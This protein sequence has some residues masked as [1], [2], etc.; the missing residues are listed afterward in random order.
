MIHLPAMWMF[1]YKNERCTRRTWMRYVAFFGLTVVSTF[2][3]YGYASWLSKTSQSEVFLLQMRPP[4][5]WQEMKDVWEIVR[6]DWIE[7]V[8][9]PYLLTLILIG[10]I[11]AALLSNPFRNNLSA[12]ALLV[13]AGAGAFLFVMLLQLSYHDYYFITIFPFVVFLLFSIGDAFSRIGKERGEHFFTICLLVAVGFQFYFSKTHLRLSHNKDN[14]EYGSTAN[15]IYFTPDLIL[16][17]GA[18]RESDQVVVVFDHS[19]NISLYLMGLK[20]VTIPYRNV[21]KTLMGYLNTGRYKFVLYNTQ[22]VNPEISFKAGD[23]PLDSVGEAD[24]VQIFKLSSSFH[25]NGIQEPLSPW[26]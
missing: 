18:I 4:K 22:S 19:P 5:S 24:G 13:M 25:P 3:W 11:V 9:H 20:G 21:Q 12:Y 7:R 15:D 26:N 23:F 10:G 6:K 1:L 14:W 17:T 2:G 8:Y 16:A